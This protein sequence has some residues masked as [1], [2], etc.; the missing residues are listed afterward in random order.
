MS[1]SGSP[2]SSSPSD[3][4]RFPIIVLGGSAGSIAALKTF[5]EALPS[6][7]GVAIIVLVHQPPDHESALADVLKG[8]TTLPVSTIDAATDV[9]GDHVY[10]LPPNRTIQV[11]GDSL[12][13]LEFERPDE[14][15]APLDQLFRRLSVFGNRIVG[16]ILSGTGADGAVGVRS[17]KECGG[18]VIA[19]DP[20]EANFDEMPRSAIETG[21]VDFVLSVAQIAVH[22]AE[23]ASLLHLR[24]EHQDLTDGDREALRK[25]FAQLRVRTGHDFSQYKDS[26][27]LRR[28]GRRMQ[29]TRTRN[30]QNYLAFLRQHEREAHKL[31]KDLL[32]SVTNF[33]RDPDAFHTLVETVIPDLFKAK[34][35]ED[36]VRVWVV[37]CATGEEAYSIAMLLLEH[38]FELDDP[39]RIQVFATDLDEDALMKAREG[40][41]PESIEGD[42]SPE[43]LTRFFQKEGDQYIVTEELRSCILFAPH[44]LLSDP[45][46]SSLDLISCRNLLIYLK[47]ELQGSLFTLFHYALRDRGYLF[48][49][50]S[51]SAETA[52]GFTTVSSEYRIFQHSEGVSLSRYLSS[53]SFSSPTAPS[54]RPEPTPKSG[55]ESTKR[56]QQHWASLESHAPPS[57][58]VDSQFSMIHLSESVGRYL[59]HPGGRPTHNILDHV[60]SE[61]HPD[62]YGALK[63]A[64]ES[65]QSTTTRPIRIAFDDTDT[66]VVLL[67]RPTTTVDGRA[68]LVMFVEV[69]PVAET[70]SSMEEASGMDDDSDVD[71]ESASGAERSD[72]GKR[73]SQDVNATP[74]PFQSPETIQQ[75][76]T[77][78]Q[79]TKAQLRA[80]IEEHETSKEEMQATNEELRSINEEYKSTAEELETSKEEL[81]SVNE[82]LQTV[83]QEL[84][85]K[86][87]E[88]SRANGDLENLMASTDIGTLFLG[89]DFKIRRYTPRIETLFSVRPGDRGRPIQELAHQ[90]DYD[91]LEQDAQTVL[92]DLMTIEREA[93]G[94][95]GKWFLVRLRPYRTLD[96]RID[97]VVVTFIDITDRKRAEEELREI[98][99][100][101][102]DRVREQTRQVRALSEALTLAEEDERHR[103]AQLL[104]DDLQQTLY[105]AEMVLDELR[106]EVEGEEEED[107][108]VDVAQTTQLE[109]IEESKEL[110][111]EAIR[112]TRVLSADLNPMV[113]DEGSLR[114]AFQRLAERMKAEYDLEVRVKT[115]DAV[116]VPDR[117]VRVL[118]FRIV[119][120]LLFNVHKHAGVDKAT[121]TARSTDRSVQVIVED[122]GCGFDP[123]TV[124]HSTTPSGMGLTSVPSRIEMLGGDFNLKTQP[125]DGTRIEVSIPYS[126]NSA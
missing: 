60:R 122:H 95:E 117:D 19:Q 7:P 29:V 108:T 53:L 3:V 38:A 83:N 40:R 57:V 21:V 115:R 77:E 87:D 2:P 50:S 22:T 59:Q 55:D 48:L 45:P 39:P 46:F 61:L 56:R 80:T 4:H 81:Q 25:I 43:R 24:P 112:T 41:Y 68:A 11:D 114:K 126:S 58:L 90:I 74:S 17:I 82:E 49:G 30:L 66:A 62:L 116:E 120:E 110:L 18:V 16:I 35:A 31:L 12:A 54:L 121:L 102:E 79:E 65:G 103:I 96:D 100:T 1:E 67:V 78:L 6:S 88:L 76:K 84:E 15:F 98:N 10:V 28:I 42:V 119:R 5:L 72:A 125:G 9:E 123:E 113:L 101:L 99:E 33:L 20:S 13:P 32:I 70:P 106:F 26:T 8:W 92:R 89:K 97:G 27:M 118:L 107:E 109:R 85:Y 75:L 73:T 63:K 69:N 86:V 34:S 37:G 104:H 91:D 105:A 71:A 111:D 36:Q 44:N 23:S 124:L 52:E 51:E 94:P 14:R 47:R 93:Q 64:F